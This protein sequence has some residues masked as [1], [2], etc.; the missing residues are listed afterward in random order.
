M[1]I[2]QLVNVRWWNAS[3]SYAVLAARALAGRG[4]R[5]LLAADAGSPAA[6]HATAA[7][8]EVRELPHLDRVAGRTNVDGVRALAAILRR[9]KPDVV[10]AHRPESHA[11]AVA[12]RFLANSRVAVVAARTDARIPRRGLLQRWLAA[13]T[14][15]TLYPATYARERDLARLGLDP[16]RTWVAPCPADTRHFAP[17]DRAAARVLLG[18][19]LDAR[20]VVMVARFA[21]VKGQVDVVDAFARLAVVD[22][23]A[24]LLLAGVEDDIRRHDLAQQAHALGVRDRVQL[25][26]VQADARVLFAAA[27]C[28]IIGSRGSEAICRVAAEWMASGRVI[29]GTRMHA[30]AEAIDDGVTGWLVEPGDVVGLADTMRLA[31][32]LDPADRAAMEVAA[33]AR[34]EGRFSLEA[35]GATLDACCQHARRGSL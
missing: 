7:G 23:H 15:A 5:S 16:A 26:D 27:D 3:A 6:V 17:G 31:F 30:V 2:L 29:I 4:H 20:L 13:R 12:A 11:W 32:A 19:P 18:V 28:G 34:A 25:L 21:H 9:E 35:F 22:D 33:R 8:L 10:I 14:E 1:T 24:R